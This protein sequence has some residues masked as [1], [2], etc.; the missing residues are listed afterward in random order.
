MGLDAFFHVAGE[1]VAD[2][3]ICAAGFERRNHLRDSAAF[4][5][6]SLDH[7]NRTVVLLDHDLNAFLDSGQHAMDVAGEFGLCNASVILS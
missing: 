6:R 2:Y 3:G 4:H 7:R 1:V 5:L